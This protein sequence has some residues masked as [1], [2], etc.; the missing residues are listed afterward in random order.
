MRYAAHTQTDRQENIT[1]KNY[2]TCTAQMWFQVI[3]QVDCPI[4]H[5]VMKQTHLYQNAI[6]WNKFDSKLLFMDRVVQR[7]KAKAMAD[8]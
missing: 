4:S 6:S 3:S 5:G 1:E 8:C 7:R 2:H